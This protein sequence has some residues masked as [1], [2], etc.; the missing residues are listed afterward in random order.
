MDRYAALLHSKWEKSDNDTVI[1]GNWIEDF[2]EYTIKVPSQLRDLLIELQNGLSI[3][4]NEMVDL[5]NELR[6]YKQNFSS[7]FKGDLD[8][9]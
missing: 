1:I 6:K 4:Y 8:D 5:E 9:N 2:N 7:I 3:K